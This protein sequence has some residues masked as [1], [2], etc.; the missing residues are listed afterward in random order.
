M[1][2]LRLLEFICFYSALFSKRKIERFIMI[3]QNP[4]QNSENPMSTIEVLAHQIS[5]MLSQPKADLEKNIKVLLSEAVS[6]MDL[7]TKEEMDRQVRLHQK[8]VQLVNELVQ[9][10]D[11]LEAAIKSKKV[12]NQ[13]C[14]ST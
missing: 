6:K 5:A 8:T 10:I 11:V 2:E 7:V 14:V 3:N 4:N 1:N 13:C 12:K 9:K